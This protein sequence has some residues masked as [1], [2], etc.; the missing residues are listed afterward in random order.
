MLNL[1]TSTD[2]TL[3]DNKP[4]WVSSKP[5]FSNTLIKVDTGIMLTE[6][7]EL[8][9]KNKIVDTSN[10]YFGTIVE[11]FL[12]C[13]IAMTILNFFQILAKSI[14]RIS[15]I[16]KKYKNLPSIKIVKNNSKILAIFLSK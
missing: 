5:Y 15:N 13:I 10:E 14:G 7:E 9:L 3:K 2:T 8:V 11:P 1:N 4:F 6:N 16:I 12:I